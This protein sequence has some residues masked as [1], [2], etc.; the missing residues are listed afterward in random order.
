MDLSSID[1]SLMKQKKCPCGSQKNYEECCKQYH[2][3]KLPEKA[4]A[5]M[6]SRYSAYALHLADYIMN[7]THPANPSYSKNRMEWK[8]SILQFSQNTTFEKLDILEFVDGEKNATVTFTAHLNQAGRVATFTEK[9]HF[10][11]VDGRWL[12]KSGEITYE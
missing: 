9:S 3:G 1:L 4:L 10:V 2:D 8:K 5:L 6:R 7:T 11:K 12:Y